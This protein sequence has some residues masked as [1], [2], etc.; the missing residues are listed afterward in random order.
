MYDS[1]MQE[2]WR[3]SQR[4][5]FVCACATLVLHAKCQ[6]AA[7]VINILQINF[8]NLMTFENFVRYL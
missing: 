1:R 8:E 2:Q 6:Y 4:I 3:L 7:T 5:I